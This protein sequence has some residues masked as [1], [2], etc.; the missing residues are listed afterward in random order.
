MRTNSYMGPAA[1]MTL[2]MLLTAMLASFGSP[3]QAKC[4]SLGGGAASYNY[5]GD[6][7]VEISMDSYDEFLREYGEES[8][9][10]GGSTQ[11]G[12]SRMIAISLSG[13]N[14]SRENASIELEL[15]TK[16]GYISGMGN[17]TSSRTGQTVQAVQAEGWLQDGK[18]NL[19]VTASSGDIY[20]LSLAD[21]GS[22]SLV[23]YFSRSDGASGAAMPEKTFNSGTARGRW[24]Q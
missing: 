7:A 12:R 23:G 20:A 6:S 2:L 9:S 8:I 11:A 14:D 4:C 24:V 22:S 5:L 3:A 13:G 15:L 21:E 17:L 16:D 19:N 18:L 10:T 1:R